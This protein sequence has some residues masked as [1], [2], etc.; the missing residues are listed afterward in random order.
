MSYPFDT[1]H[2][3]DDAPNY[4]FKVGYSLITLDDIHDGWVSI[5]LKWILGEGDNK[6]KEMDQLINNIFSFVF[7][8]FLKL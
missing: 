3:E 4:K 8:F 7:Y 5:S 1:S 2:N 6:I